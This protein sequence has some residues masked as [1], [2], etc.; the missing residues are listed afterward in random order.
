MK[1]LAH[2]PSR[3]S[4]FGGGSDIAPFASVYGGLTIT[5][6]INIRQTV[7]VR[8]EEDMWQSPLHSFPPQ[9][10]P[11][12]Y[13]EV[14][15]KYGINGMHHASVESG[16]QGI[17]GAG[18]GSSAS[19]TVALVGAIHRL[20]GL[21]L[22]KDKIAESAWDTEVNRL[23][24]FGGKQDQ[25]AS[26]FGGFNL[27]MIR[28]AVRV[29]PLNPLFLDDLVAHL[30]LFYIGGTRSS[31]HIQ[32]GFMNMTSQQERK[33]TSLK[34]LAEEALVHI[35]RGNVYEIGRLLDKAWTIK[36]SSNKGVSNAR[37]NKIYKGAIEHGALGGKILGAGGGGYMLFCI[38]QKNQKKF[39][40]HMR[41]Q[42][43]EHIDY[44][45]DFN[46]MEARVL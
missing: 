31:A 12:L 35:S 30:L 4:L 46:G 29:V 38:P 42:G 22:D 28:D 44:S 33:L 27:L 8:T 1:I 25:W 18:L 10:D 2:A 32:T 5:M 34:E 39:I 24:W 3:I 15:K 43:I 13:Y 26:S 19:A 45:V 6:A 11:H 23:G 37:I 36:K 20:Q 21:P 41:Q 7:I 17:I 40:Q 9:A 14:F 16:F